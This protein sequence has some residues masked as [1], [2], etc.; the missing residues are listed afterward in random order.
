[1]IA[2]VKDGGSLD[3][4]RLTSTYWQS[5]LDRLQPDNDSS[6]TVSGAHAEAPNN[7][8]SYIVRQGPVRVKVMLPV[9]SQA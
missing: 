5:Q 1:M 8:H 7:I 6:F 9:T 3:Y 2:L 4:E